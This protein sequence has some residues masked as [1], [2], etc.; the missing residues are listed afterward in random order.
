MRQ[1]RKISS[2]AQSP[3]Y[4]TISAGPIEKASRIRLA[5]FAAVRIDSALDR[6]GT[7]GDPADFGG[8]GFG[9]GG[10]AE[11]GGAAL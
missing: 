10:G 2:L 8:A 3:E 9:V 1:A 11:Q 4:S 5:L 6:C 7:G